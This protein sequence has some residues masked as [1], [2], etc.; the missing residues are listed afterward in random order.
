MKKLLM[1]LGAI[2]LG[3]IML[4]VVTMAGLGFIAYTNSKGNTQIAVKGVRT[5]SQTWSPKNMSELATPYL[6]GVLNSSDGKLAMRRMSRL[7]KLLIAKRP[8][9][10]SYAFA[11]GEGTTA[12]VTF[13]GLFQNGE[14]DVI[15]RLRNNGNGM[16]LNG[17]RTLNSKLKNPSE[18]EI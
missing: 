7:G 13:R 17:V 14:A 2:F 12:T 10:T 6:Y 18:R 5:L 11:M 9:Q 15:V 8:T 1:S 4:A 16:R 3:L